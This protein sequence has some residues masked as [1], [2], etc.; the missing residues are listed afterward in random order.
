MKP[1][2][3]A[4]LPWY[5]QAGYVIL[6]LVLFFPLGIALMWWNRLWSHRTRVIISA[7]AGALFI[8]RLVTPAPPRTSAGIGSSGA[9]P[10]QRRT[11][12][13]AEPSAVTATKTIEQAATPSASELASANAAPRKLTKSEAQAMLK[14]MEVL[15]QQGREMETL[16]SSTDDDPGR[17]ARLRRCGELMRERQA[18]VREIR[19]RAAGLPGSVAQLRIAATNLELC[20]SCSESLAPSSCNDARDA[21][22]RGKAA[23]A[24]ATW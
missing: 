5:R 23:L 11:K 7:I 2:T 1:H 15:L 20:V 22:R 6:T 17:L 16:R 10:A 9:T 12:S 19:K 18:H 14:E 21:L 3:S 13:G 24:K 8:I 4:A